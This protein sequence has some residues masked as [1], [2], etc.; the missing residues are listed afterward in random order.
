MRIILF[1]Q[2]E[3]F[4]NPEGTM[5]ANNGHTH[6]ESRNKNRSNV[7]K[8]DYEQ[9]EAT[10][11]G[12]CLE[13][14]ESAT[15]NDQRLIRGTEEV[16]EHPR[17]EQTHEDNK[18]EWIRKERNTKDQSNYSIIIDTEVR[19]VLADP[20]GGF[21]EALG[22]R[23][24]RTVN[25]FTPRTALREAITDGIGEVADEGAEGRCGN[26]PSRFGGDATSG[27]VGLGIGDGEDGRA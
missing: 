6:H 14:R 18:R 23:E 8:K 15:K 11:E 25:E 21:R 9:S 3:I 22:F 1:I 16:K 27:S 2:E 5:S 12:Q 13:I 26:G 17:S 10:Q 7:G 24:G 4:R 19:V 20:K